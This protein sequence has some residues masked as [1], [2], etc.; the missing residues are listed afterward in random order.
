MWLWLSRRTSYSIISCRHAPNSETPPM[1][2]CVEAKGEA[3]FS[4]FTIIGG[5]ITKSNNQVIHKR[6][7]MHLLGFYTRVSYQTKK[8]PGHRSQRTCRIY[9]RQTS[10]HPPPSNL[11]GASPIPSRR[12]SLGRDIPCPQRYR[13]FCFFPNALS[14]VRRRVVLVATAARAVEQ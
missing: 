3:Q 10:E 8:K 9:S 5:T 13:L 7:R 11:G 1:Y 12:E 14:H 6:K 2:C 4:K